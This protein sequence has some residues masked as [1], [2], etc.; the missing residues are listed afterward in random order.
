MEDIQ[1]KQGQLKELINSFKIKIFDVMMLLVKTKHTSNLYKM[2]DQI[3]AAILMIV[4]FVQIMGYLFD[5]DV[6][7][8]V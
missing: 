8:Q 2:L 1:L 6:N 5:R 3:Y 7:F 4:S